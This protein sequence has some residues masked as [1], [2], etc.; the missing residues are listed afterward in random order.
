MLRTI[1]DPYVS[2]GINTL[3]EDEFENVRKLAVYNQDDALREYVLP[4][5]SVVA[6]KEPYYKFNGQDDC[7]VRVDH[8]SDL[9]VLVG[10]ES[11]V[12]SQFKESLNGKQ[13]STKQWKA[14]GDKKFLAKDY[15]ATI[16][17]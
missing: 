2:S 13:P 9:H 4:K 7:V 1:T 3:I 8:P 17:W 12:P 11:I 14:A 15:L 6:I 16:S 5:D 10:L